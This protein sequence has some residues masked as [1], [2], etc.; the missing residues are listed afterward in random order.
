MRVIK[1]RLDPPVLPTDGT[2]TLFATSYQWGLDYT[3]EDASLIKGTDEKN[4]TDLYSK[5]ISVDVADNVVI[6]VRVKYHFN[7]LN[8][9]TNQYEE[10]ATIWSRAVPVSNKDNRLKLSS[11]IINTPILQANINDE[12][13]LIEISGSDYGM[14]SGYTE[15]GYTNWRIEDLN[16][17]LYFSREDDESNLTD[18]V[19]ENNLDSGKIY[20]VMCQYGAVDNTESN[21]GVKLLPNYSPYA[22]VFEYDAPEDLVVNRQYYYRIKLWSTGFNYYDLKIVNKVTEEVLYTIEKQAQTT[23][24]L[25]ITK[26]TY[27]EI[28]DVQI[29]INLHF[30]DT[31]GEYT[32]GWTLVKETSLSRNYI[33]PFRPKTEYANKYSDLKEVPRLLT[34]GLTCITTREL[35]DYKTLCSDFTTNGLWIY[36]TAENTLK[37]IKKV[38]TFEDDLDFDYINIIQL[39]NHNVLI[40]TVEY[41][42]DKQKYSKFY[43]FEYDSVKTELTLLATKVR[44]D[45]RYCTSMNNSL[46]VDHKGNCYYVPAM[47]VPGDGTEERETLILRKLNTETL[48]ITDITLPFAAVYNVGMFVDYNNNFYVFGGCSR[49]SYGTEVTDTDNA[50]E[51]Y[52]ERTN[53]IIY[54]INTEDN[55]FTEFVSFDDTKL[56]TN[57]YTLHAFRRLDNKIVFLNACHSGDGMK[58]DQFVL[59]DIDKKEFT[60]TKLNGILNAPVRSQLVL[61][62]G[63][64]VRITS[65]IKD[66]QYV[67]VY[68]SN[69]TEIA[70][71]QD[72]GTIDEEAGYSNE[73][74][75]VILTVGDG[76]I[77][78]IEDIYKYTSIV[79][80]GTGIV[81]WFTPQGVTELTSKTYIV[82]TPTTSQDN[83]DFATPCIDWNANQYDSVL[84]LDGAQLILTAN[85]TDNTGSSGGG[86]GTGT[87]GTVIKDI[88]EIQPGTSGGG[89]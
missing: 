19:A 84:V 65:M 35:F 31:T 30:K 72:F 85:N 44:Y 89:N 12:L 42:N 6:Y 26:D 36:T 16:N 37:K 78:N 13:G 58:Y 51:E 52:W 71:I 82:Y 45:E 4:T 81:R 9:N 24:K 18:I 20:R 1:I 2:L 53:S 17:T 40:D 70:N 3:F 74:G 68:R 61:I 43:L 23:N 14:Y 41:G 27:D 86:T 46:A 21:Y 80:N 32:T 22:A 64:I 63:D 5:K 49:I 76:E 73:F 69:S 39:P 60:Y 79:I 47:K 54:K 11:S 77:V 15:H 88:V 75:N 25:T 62:S 33:Y 57:V 87:G 55:T 10:K 8:K 29:Y 7:Y 34:N 28:Q 48:E 59:L 56:P 38:Y 83:K 50:R 67:L 66:P